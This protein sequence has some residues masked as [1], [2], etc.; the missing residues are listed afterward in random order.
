MA[1]FGAVDLSACSK[2]E[3]AKPAPEP[4]VAG[5]VVSF[6]DQKEPPG[7]RLAI[8][9]GNAGQSL[10]VPGRL[11]WDEDHT[12]R[13]YAPYAGRIER[14][15]VAVGQSV[16]RGQP[17]AD[18]GSADIGQAQ[19]D[20]HK[21]DADLALTR[22]AVERARDL[23]EGGVIA[24]KELLQAEADHARAQAE[25]ARARARLAQY[26]VAA[27]S[28][29]QGLS[30]A[31]P[32]AGVVVER[33]GNPGGEVRTDVQGPPLFTISDPSS[34]WAVLD[35]DETQL[36]A[37]KPGDSIELHSAAWPD[38]EFKASVTSVAASV[39]PASRTVK[40]RARVPNAQFR[41]KAEMF[42]TAT[43]I[44]SVALPVVPADAVFLLGDRSY[45][46]VKAGPGR[47]RRCEVKVRGAGP[48]AWT[49]LQGVNTGESVV[50]GGGLYFNQLLDSAK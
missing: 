48:Q 32:L 4:S 15:R 38:M 27:K 39:D 14:L 29:T 16:K 1:L 17:L 8:V 49:V 12:T 18:M 3:E 31:A 45:V 24:R 47:Y 20:L 37:F 6:P 11:T 26:G 22:S 36:A 2:P 5:D 19:A 42:V 28:V 7:V 35:V 23:S 50:V 13:V 25:A 43:A 46:F 41:L 10:D 40:V 34:L 30:L 9:G 44:Q 21:A 33:N